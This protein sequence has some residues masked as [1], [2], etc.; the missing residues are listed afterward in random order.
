M[1]RAIIFDCFGVLYGGSIDYLRSLA[2]ADRVRDVTD[3]NQQKD[4]G[5]LTYEEYLAQTGDIL[6]KSPAE[7]DHIMRER[8]V[9]NEELVAQVR[10]L[11]RECK[12]GLLSN[13]GEKMFE[14][15]FTP[16]EANELF[17]VV[18]L[19]YKEGLAK[20]NPAIFTLA[21]ERMGV[22][23]GEC[24]MVDDLASNCEGA[25]SAGMLAVQHVTNELTREK[26]A[27]LVRIST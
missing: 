14:Q 20:P 6:G 7:I 1:I 13:V 22:S 19:S 2:P 15:L 21:A 23:T 12:I 27:R 25:E 9:R 4:Y 3:L 8:H 5:F 10:E 16:A 11:R 17:D 18:V 24:L 26:I